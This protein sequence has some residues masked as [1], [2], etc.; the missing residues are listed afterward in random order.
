MGKG[1][2]ARRMDL[3]AVG[4]DFR[5]FGVVEAAR[6][7]GLD[8]STVSRWAKSGRL[9]LNNC[10][11]P[12]SIEA[13]SVVPQSNSAV[14]A[15]AHINGTEAVLLPPPEDW[16][17]RIRAKYDLDDTE[18]ELVTLVGQALAMAHDVALPATTRL[19]AMQRFEALT[20]RLDL[21]EDTSGANQTGRRWPQRAS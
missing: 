13:P 16:A 21:P 10:S 1:W 8:K 2:R 5:R 14:C 15:I 12:P 18:S 4:A 20:K 17:A 11:H 6:R 19:V 9:D 7:H 3:A